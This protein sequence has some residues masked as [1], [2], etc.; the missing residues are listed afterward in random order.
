LE[1]IVVGVIAGLL[2]GILGGFLG[3]GG[4]VIYVPAMVLLLGEEQ[5]LAQ[6]V[7]LA[8]IIVTALVGGTTH[9]RQGNVDVRIVAWVAPAAAAAGLGAAFLAD[10]IDASILRRIFAVVVL[11]IGATMLLGTLRRERAGEEQ[12]T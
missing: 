7:S 1:E 10:I 2:G 3:V 12:R 11:Y 6:G 9:L 5:Q 8:V 4:G